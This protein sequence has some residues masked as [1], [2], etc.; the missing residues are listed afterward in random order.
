M[1]IDTTVCAIIEC[2][3]ANLRIKKKQRIRK[4]CHSFR[5]RAHLFV[6][7]QTTY[8]I[9]VDKND[10]ASSTRTVLMYHN[11]RFVQKHMQKWFPGRTD[12]N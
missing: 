12:I 3:E 2:F 7:K 6:I 8:R 5:L 1:R 4:L 11:F 10:K 9:K